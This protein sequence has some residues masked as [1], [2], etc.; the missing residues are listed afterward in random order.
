MNQPGKEISGKSSEAVRC[1]Q[2]A[3]LITNIVPS[4]TEQSRKIGGQNRGQGLRGSQL[5]H[6]AEIGFAPHVARM[7]IYGLLKCGGERQQGGSLSRD[8][9]ELRE[10]IN[11]VR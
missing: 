8:H 11:I 5:C 10:A 3:Q 9:A 2:I 7:R 4:R 6:L 1:G